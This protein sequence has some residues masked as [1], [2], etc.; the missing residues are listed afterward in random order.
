[1]KPPASPDG[2]PAFK[3]V[4]KIATPSRIPWVMVRDKIRRTIESGMVSNDRQVS[5]LEKMLSAITGTG[6]AAVSSGSAGLTLLL[7]A[8]KVKGYVLMPSFTFPASA[9]A[10]AWNS[11]KMRFADIDPETFCIDPDDVSEKIDRR[12]GCIMGVPIFGVPCKIEA[13]QE[14]ADDYHI[15]LIFDSAHALGSKHANQYLGRFGKAEVFS[16]SPAKIVTGCEG[17]AVCST[18]HELIEKVRILRNYGSTGN[19]CEDTGMNAR[20]TEISAIIASTLLERIED[21]IRYRKRIEDRY[22][23]IL[24]KVPGISFQSCPP[25]DR[26]NHQTF[27]ILISPQEF[28][29]DRDTL[30]KALMAENIE[31]RVYFKPIH[32]LKPYRRIES[33]LPVTEDIYSRILALPLHERMTISDASKVANCIRDIHPSPE[34][35]G[36]CRLRYA[37]PL[38]P[39]FLG[40]L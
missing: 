36:E 25:E 14:I 10:V 3:E 5:Y 26:P 11:L 38:P 16:F 1:M 39:S 23:S 4:L 9:H 28:G 18:S 8:L 21:A 19:D 35:R 17:G 13:L 6:C 32:H 33:R 34:R 30:Q 24:Q 29:M 2:T 7:R 37:Q 22:R 15:P 27:A 40:N 12:C 20:M 31:T